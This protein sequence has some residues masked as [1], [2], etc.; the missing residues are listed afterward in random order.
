MGLTAPIIETLAR[1]HKFRP[2]SGDVLLIGRQTVY[3]TAAQLLDLYRDFG[4]DVG[5]VSADEI[6][7]DRSTRD[8]QAELGD[9]AWVSD[10]AVFRLLGI[11]S[12]RALDVSAYEGAEIIHDLNRPV[13]ESLK[14]IAD[15]VIDGSTLDNTFNAAQ[16]LMN[17]GEIL[18]PGGRLF[19]VNAFSS[20]NAAY[21]LLPPITWL[22]YFVYNGF[23][24][25]Q[26]YIIVGTRGGP[27]NAFYMD[28]DAV[29]EQR[30]HMGRFAS[31]YPLACFVFAEKGAHSTAG[32]TPIQQDYRSP[33]D[34]DAFLRN[35]DVMRKSE[36]PLLFRS[37]QP[38]FLED[39]PG[40][41]RYVDSEFQAT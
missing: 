8:R 24:D 6:E 7:I 13:P 12:L 23:A 11:D 2:L 30:R 18:R 16:A 15:I 27:S 38:R 26:I 21:A 9:H 29:Y 14:G 31:S 34:W 3:L 40:G 5:A 33:E 32:K 1:E 36:R 20:H 10:R 17:F 22:D 41:H 37:D 39:V 19:A 25:C 35:L 4:I 28:L